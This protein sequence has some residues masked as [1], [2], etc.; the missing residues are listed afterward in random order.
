MQEDTPPRGSI[1]LRL[2]NIPVT[3]YP[4]SW[5]MLAIL[6]GGLSISNK[7]EIANVL[8]FVVAGMLCLIVHEM[9]HALTGYRLTGSLPR[10]AIAGLG[11][12]TYTPVIP[13]TRVGY[14]GMV[15]AGPFASFLLGVLAGAIFGL[16]IGDVAAGVRFSLLAPLPLEFDED[17]LFYIAMGMGDSGMPE[18]LFMFYMHIFSVCLWWT[19]FNLLPIF[20]LDGGKLLGTLLNNDR[21]ACIIGLVFGG[22]LCLLCMLWLVKGGGSMWNVFIV[23]YLTY[24]NYSVLRS[25]K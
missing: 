6:G 25:M 14:F 15:F 23:A 22:A 21:L 20:P 3:I 7:G 18:Q 4:I 10:V 9:G 11:G 12:V 8:F 16:Q 1:S 5:I 19:I 13:R 24:M 2:F 17:F